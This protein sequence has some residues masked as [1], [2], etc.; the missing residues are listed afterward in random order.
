M[1]EISEHVIVGIDTHKLTHVVALITSTGMRIDAKC[2]TACSEGYDQA[3][4]WVYEYGIPQ[5][6]GIEAT[7]S[8]GV[9]IYEYFRDH[10][11]EC[12]EVYKPDKEQRRRRGKDDAIDA[13]QA[14]Q[15]ALCYERCV[16]AK[17]KTEKLKALEFL[18]ASYK[19]ATKHQTALTNALHAAI[20]K[21]P[22][23]MKEKL[24]SLSTSEL[25]KTCAN[26]RISKKEK[27]FFDL[28]KLSMR[29]QARQIQ[30]IIEENKMLEKELEHLTHELAP[31][32]KSLQGVGCHGV[33]KLLSAAGQN[34][35]RMKSEASFS[36]ICGTSPIPVSSGNTHHFRLNR[37]GNRQANCAIHT[38]ALARMRLCPKTKLFIEKKRSEGKTNK[39][40]IRA[41]KRYL[42]R[43]VYYA[44]KSDLKTLG[45]V[46]S[47]TRSTDQVV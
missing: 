20:I 13:F 2:F 1:A 21:L 33:A 31:K 38:M 25:I 40:A 4:R 41:L 39:D 5:R 9:G 29:A 45:Y 44:L 26:F 35:D 22:E 16:P 24:R 18:E 10:G 43:E 30:M 47:I 14:A 3:L 17:E 8:Y 27:S 7:G 42:S 36:M 32:T 6:A 19:L 15:A 28:I 37:G 11:I 12:F 23:D 34:I 46:S